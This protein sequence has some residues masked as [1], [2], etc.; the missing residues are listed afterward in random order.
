MYL[1][2]WN[3]RILLHLIFHKLNEPN[4]GGHDDS[5]SQFLEITLIFSH[6]WSPAV[7]KETSSAGT[8]GWGEQNT[9]EFGKER[10]LSALF[11]KTQMH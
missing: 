4:T 11:Q 10:F 5:K 8:A 7:I 1:T 9:A 2:H 3:S 6:I